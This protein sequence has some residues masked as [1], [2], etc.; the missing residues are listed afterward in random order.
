MENKHMKR[1][2][3][4]L[5]IPETQNKTIRGHYCTLARMAKLNRLTTPSAGEDV[6]LLEHSYTAGGIVI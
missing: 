3:T 2:S 1:F 6:E 4:L 5:I